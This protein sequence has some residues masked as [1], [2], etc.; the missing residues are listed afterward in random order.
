[1]R[2]LPQAAIDALAS[3][4][5]VLSAL[6]QLDLPTP[7]YA[8]TAQVISWNGNTYRPD[9]GL[10][11]VPDITQDFNLSA[12]SLTLTF[13]DASE[14]ILSSA[15]Q[16]GY[17]DAQLDIH[18]AIINPADYSVLHVIPSVYRGYCEELQPSDTAKTSFTFKN[19]MH[20]FDRKAGRKTNTPSQQRYYEHDNTFDQITSASGNWL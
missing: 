7:I 8:S 5:V 19:H 12:N 1:M 13:A 4:V 15:R 10:I 11:S 17:A 9:T 18:I 3:D 16:N 20:K 14:Q 6:V 2:N